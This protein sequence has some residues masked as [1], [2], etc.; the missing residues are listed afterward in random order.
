MYKETI[1]PGKFYF[2]IGD[3]PIK[4]RGSSPYVA[5][6]GDNI[7]PLIEHAQG[8]GHYLPEGPLNSYLRGLACPPE[9]WRWINGWYYLCFPPMSTKGKLPRVV[10][11]R[12]TWTPEDG[13]EAWLEMP[14]VGNY[15]EGAD[16]I[17][18]ECVSFIAGGKS[19][20]Y[21]CNAWNTH[22]HLTKYSTRGFDDGE[23]T[24]QE[25]RIL[26][27][28]AQGIVWRICCGALMKEN[29]QKI[30]MILWLRK[31]YPKSCPGDFAKLLFEDT[32][33]DVL[34][35]ILAEVAK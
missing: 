17:G 32:P 8:A 10:Y 6:L 16:T 12:D 5:F 20:L 26:N 35:I 14:F 1:R 28:V 11:F 27:Q 18:D 33:F 24:I 19:F 22:V 21:F 34:K 9:R 2:K 3:L 7:S 29:K 4:T 15:W 23:L 13:V 30:R 31:S 25:K